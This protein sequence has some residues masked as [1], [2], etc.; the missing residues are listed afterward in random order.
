MK[1]TYRWGKQFQVRIGTYRLGDVNVE[2]YAQDKDEAEFHFVPDNKSL[3]RIKIGFGYDQWWRVLEGLL[4]ESCEFL[5]CQKGVRFEQS[6]RLST[7]YEGLRFFYDHDTFTEIK[8]AQAY[9]LDDATP[10]LYA[11]WK[12]FKSWEKQRHNV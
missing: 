12:S 10:P 11:A 9:F 6:G 4:H 7:G 5:A 2:L 1:K 3:P 8:A